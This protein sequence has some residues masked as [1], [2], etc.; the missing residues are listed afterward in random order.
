MVGRITLIQAVARPHISLRCLKSRYISL[1]TSYYL[2]SMKNQ[3][4]WQL[5]S[6][7]KYSGFSYQILK[8]CQQN[9]HSLW[10]RVVQYEDSSLTHGAR[11]TFSF[12][13]G[14]HWCLDLVPIMPEISCNCNVIGES[15][16]KLNRSHFNYQDCDT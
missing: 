13:S 12:T 7:N 14:V 1:K 5:F 2:I 11:E 15:W 9:W 16:D 3:W 10:F 6:T 4:T 8:L